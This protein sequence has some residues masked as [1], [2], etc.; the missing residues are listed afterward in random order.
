MKPQ[1]EIGF[2]NGRIAL[3]FDRHSTAYCRGY[4]SERLEKFISYS[5][6]SKTS[7]DLTVRRPPALL[8]KTLVD[9]VPGN[10]SAF[11]FMELSAN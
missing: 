10:L 3:K 2:H 1:S 8:I 5:R 11:A 9:I 7:R 4:I 6:G